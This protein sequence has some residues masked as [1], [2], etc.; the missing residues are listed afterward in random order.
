MRRPKKPKTNV[1]RDYDMKATLEHVTTC[2]DRR[3]DMLTPLS[4]PALKIWAATME[5]EDILAVK[6]LLKHPNAEAMFRLT[7]Q[8]IIEFPTV[9]YVA[10]HVPDPFSKARAHL[11]L[12]HP[13]LGNSYSSITP[14]QLNDPDMRCQL[15]EWFTKRV[16]LMH[17]AYIVHHRVKLLLNNCGT[18]RQVARAWPELQGFMTSDMRAAI[19]AARVRSPLPEFIRDHPAYTRAALG[20]LNDWISQALMLDDPNFV[21]SIEIR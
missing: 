9:N 2:M 19:A 17:E 11:P 16:E 8:V 13:V 20:P 7:K 15:Q 5:R 18:Y 6:R 21:D 14:D 3:A 4:I 10:E 1:E 12:Q